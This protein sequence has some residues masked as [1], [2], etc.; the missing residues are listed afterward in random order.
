[1]LNEQLKEIRS[2]IGNSQKEMANILEI[3]YRTYVNYEND[4]SQPSSDFI[5][6]IRKKLG[7]SMDYLFDGKE[8]MFEW[9]SDRNK[10]IPKVLSHLRRSEVSVDDGEIVYIPVVAL[11]SEPKPDIESLPVLR[12]FVKPFDPDNVKCYTVRG[13]SMYPTLCDGDRVVYVEG[14]IQGSGIYV[15]E[16]MYYW[17]AKRLAFRSDGSILVTADADKTQ[18]EVVT[19]KAFKIYGRALFWIH[20]Q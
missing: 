2:R 14:N 8:P 13:Q 11:D 12:K 19:L 9:E 18:E 3:P 5:N 7:V 1:M 4:L 20:K 10:P 17:G 6:L 15:V 16:G